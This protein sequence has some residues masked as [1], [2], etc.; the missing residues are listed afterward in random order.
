MRPQALEHFLLRLPGQ[1][2]LPTERFRVRLIF[3]VAVHQSTDGTRL[4]NRS[5]GGFWVGNCLEESKLLNQP[6]RGA[7]LF[8]AQLLRL[9]ANSVLFFLHS[10]LVCTWRFCV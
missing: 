6:S 5:P 3:D 2:Q 10:L 7:D 9:H 4:Q 8:E 1:L